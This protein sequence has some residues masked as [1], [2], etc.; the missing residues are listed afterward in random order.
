MEDMSRRR[1]WIPGAEKEVA[2][3]GL[4]PAVGES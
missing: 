3:S 1:N 2:D 4:P